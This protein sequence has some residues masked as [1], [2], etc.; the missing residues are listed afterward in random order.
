[1]SPFEERT[2]RRWFVE[3]RRGAVHEYDSED[4]ARAAA[5]HPNAVRVLFQDVTFGPL[6]EVDR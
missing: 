1:M 6:V 3:D 4:A 2:E 5:G